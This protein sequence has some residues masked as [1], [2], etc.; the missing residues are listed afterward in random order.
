MR[1]AE[2]K[3]FT[4]RN[5]E[6]N[7]KNSIIKHVIN[8]NKKILFQDEFILNDSSYIADIKIFCEKFNDF[9]LWMWVHPYP[10][11]YPCKTAVWNQHIKAKAVYSLYLAPVTVSEMKEIRY[12]GLPSTHHFELSVAHELCYC[13][14]IS[15]SLTRTSCINI[16]IGV[17]RIYT[18]YWETVFGSKIMSAA[19]TNHLP[20]KQL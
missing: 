13:I 3:H 9:F 8:K 1:A 7:R 18:H 4:D 12:V 17:I 11:R 5:K 10:K 15:Y 16:R 2:K 14:V 6:K 19:A 20:N